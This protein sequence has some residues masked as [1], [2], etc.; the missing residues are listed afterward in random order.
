MLGPL[1][2]EERHE[3]VP[4]A[5]G[6]AAVACPARP[7]R[8]PRKRRRKGVLPTVGGLLVGP[9]ELIRHRAFGTFER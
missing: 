5:A 9:R 3:H 1:F 7:G 6:L 2:G 4:G 8:L